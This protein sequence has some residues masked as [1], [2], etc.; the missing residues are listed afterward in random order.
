MN[1]Y[2]NNFLTINTKCININFK[3]LKNNDS[4]RAYCIFNRK[5]GTGSEWRFTS[6]RLVHGEE[7]CGE[8]NM[9]RNK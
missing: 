4:K 7:T 5:A 1:T 6:A 9:K 8:E 3:I 2:K